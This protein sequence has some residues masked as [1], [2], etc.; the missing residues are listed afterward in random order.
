MVA[1][2][3]PILV[4]LLACAA[5]ALALLPATARAEANLSVP[6]AQ[7]LMATAHAL[8]IARWGADAC[9]GQVAVSWTHM[10][11][12]INARSQWMSLDPKDA[13]TYSECAVAYNLDVEWDWPKLCTVIEHELGHLSGHSHV[14]EPHDVM[15][16]YYIYPTS[17]CAPTATAVPR[18]SHAAPRKPTAAA[19]RGTASKAAVAKRKAS[20]K[21][22][23][24]SQR[25]PPSRLRTTEHRKRRTPRARISVAV[26]PSLSVP[27]PCAPH[28]PAVDLSGASFFGCEPAA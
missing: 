13:T 10:G 21:R 1:S 5:L 7:P 18:P 19:R 15:S 2:C 22:R 8:A 27:S 23:P 14:D 6:A 9:G 25:H 3:S 24:R 4:R 17:E 16:P 11:L 28:L 26:A 12:G 20:A